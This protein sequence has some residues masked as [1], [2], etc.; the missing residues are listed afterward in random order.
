M[1]SFQI[2][3]LIGAGATM[4]LSWK[5]PRAKGL[6]ALGVAS[7]F[8]STLYSRHAIPFMPA[9]AVA[10]FFDALVCL[11]IYYAG[12]ERWELLIW[13]VFQTMVLV[14][15]LY[16]WGAI[17]PHSVY[18]IALE[19]L[20]WLALVVIG[21]TACLE[22]LGRDKLLGNTRSHDFSWLALALRQKRKS[23]PWTT[24]R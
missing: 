23:D 12:R 3:L 2:A 4:A 5:L 11:W 14:N 6:I 16:L 21:T 10:V 7:F 13:R 8:F 1:N 15:L 9:P 18:V 19:A 17:G 22:R 24:A 20:N